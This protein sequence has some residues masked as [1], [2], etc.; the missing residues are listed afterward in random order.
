MK[1]FF[2]IWLKNIKEIADPRN[3]P[4]LPIELIQYARDR[5]LYHRQ[6]IGRYPI[7]PLP[8]LFERGRRPPFDA[9]YVYQAYWATDRIL[10]T[11]PLGFHVD[12]SSHIP[13]VA[14]LSA[15]LPVI[16]MEFTPPPVQLPSLKKLSGSLLSLPF[17]DGSVS[18]LTCLHVIEHVGLGRYGDP[19]ESDGCWKALRELE[20]IM[21]PGGNLFISVPNGKPAVYF[22]SGYVFEASHIKE[23]MKT[24]ELVEF[25]YVDDNGGFVEF[26]GFEDIAGMTYAL[27]LFHFKRAE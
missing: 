7:K 27:G 19:I 3:L 23:A 20:R 11:S 13:F 2:S 15:H 9:H 8:V 1:L 5:R 12:I 18:S 21:A 16:Q 22:N 4:V 25:S 6:Y 14:Q 24:L 26:G 17:R 10:K